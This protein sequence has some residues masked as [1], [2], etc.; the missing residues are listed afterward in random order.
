MIAVGENIGIVSQ[1]A[2]ATDDVYHGHCP[3]ED[4]VSN[5]YATEL[6][7]YQYDLNHNSMLTPIGSLPFEAISSSRCFDPPGVVILNQQIYVIKKTEWQ[8]FFRISVYNRCGILQSEFQIK[9]RNVKQS[10]G[11]DVFSG[12][13]DSLWILKQIEIGKTCLRKYSTK[14]QLL[15]TF[16][17]DCDFRFYCLDANNHLYINSGTRH[18]YKYK[19][20][21]DTSEGIINVGPPVG[22]YENILGVSDVKLCYN[23]AAD[24]L[25]FQSTMNQ[26][27]LSELSLQELSLKDGQTRKICKG[28]SNLTGDQYPMF[29]S[30]NGSVVL[31]NY[32]QVMCVN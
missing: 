15:S 24:S 22:I 5:Y 2:F 10:F 30:P 31:S 4:D 29:V 16:Y 27:G 7:I 25:I 12:Y 11:G 28:L 32:E 20:G 17:I 1:N 19:L 8:H 23:P 13:G 9:E 6:R 26:F 18:F 14:G 3:D 21:K